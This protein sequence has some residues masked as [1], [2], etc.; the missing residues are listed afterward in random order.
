[1]YERLTRD[2][3]GRNMSKNN[4][5]FGINNVLKIISRDGACVHFCGVGGVGMSALFRL[6]EHFGIRVTGTDRARGEYLDALMREGACV[7]CGAQGATSLPDGVDLVVYSL[8][9]DERDPLLVEAEAR[10]VP[11]VSRAEYLGAL[12]TCFGRSIAVSGSHGKS[13]VTAMLAHIFEHSGRNPTVLSGAAL[14]IGGTS[15]RIGALDYL[16]FESCEYKDSFL[17]PRPDIGVFLNLELDHVDWFSD[18]DDISAS[19]L[20]AMNKAGRAVVNTD[21]REI[22]KNAE[23]LYTPPISFGKSA[24]ADYRIITEDESARA[25]KFALVHRGTPLGRVDLPMIGSFNI[26][27]AA[28]AIAAAMEC[29]ITFDECRTAL[30]TFFGIG[31][32]LERIGALGDRPVY[33][34][35]AHH[36][37]EIAEG[38]KAVKGDTGGPVTVIFGPH[39]YS[40]TK[41]LWQGFVNSLCMAEHIIL[42]EI[43]AIREVEIEGVSSARLAAECGA[44]IAHDP[45]ELRQLLS[46]A[47]GAVIIMGAAD[48]EWVKKVVLNS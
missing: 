14:S 38:I 19:F 4:S 25:L 27:N 17:I 31:R 12:A 41:G 2:G 26:Y 1:M 37:T 7:S 11:A 42:T 34:D 33:Y 5:S 40:R 23:R 45:D 32:R 47:C 46:E 8:A 24:N 43:S 36:P 15:A 21:D 30:S 35:Y 3:R 20:R 10:G 9:L 28:A 29:G 48:M 44:G 18:L 13:T 6:S 22:A 39:T 16:V